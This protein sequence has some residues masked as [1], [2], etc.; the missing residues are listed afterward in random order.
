L[1]GETQP[2]EARELFTVCCLG[3]WPEWIIQRI[4]HGGLEPNVY[5]RRRKILEAGLDKVTDHARA[6]RRT[7]ELAVDEPVREPLNSTARQSLAAR[8]VDRTVYVDLEGAKLFE[9]ERI[10]RALRA[11]G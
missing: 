2:E 3:R 1:Q 10:R 5:R 9:V 4:A 11:S 7:T 6:Q 8:L